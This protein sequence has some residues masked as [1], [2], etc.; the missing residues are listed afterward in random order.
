MNKA[1][2]NTAWILGEKVMLALAG[3]FI[4]V[5]VARYLGP[6]E[7][8]LISLALAIVALITPMVKMGG[9]NVVFNRL[10]RNRHSGLLLMAASTRVRAIN[11]VIICTLLTIGAW[12]YFDTPKQMA[13]FSIIIWGSFFT[14]NEVYSVFFNSS[15]DS[16]F[17]TVAQ[18]IALG[19]GVA[20]KFAFIKLG[21]T[22]GFFAAANIIQWAV[23][24]FIKQHLFRR[25]TREIAHTFK[26]RSRRHSRHIVQVGIPLA[27]SSLSIALYTRTD[28]I[29]LGSM[30]DE[31]HVGWYSAA[32]TLSQGWMMFPM[33]LMT[34]WMV[35]INQAAR[36]SNPALFEHRIRRL[37][38]AVFVVAVI[39]A[40]LMG[41]FRVELI[42]L[43]YGD[44]YGPAASVLGI[45]VI[46]SVF[47][48]LGTSA[49]N[50]IT[51]MG[52]Y[53]F[54]LKKMLFVSA[55]NIVL[56]YLLIPHF[57]L[58]GAALSTL[59]AEILSAV[60]LNLFYRRGR[61]L[62][63]QMTAFMGARPAP[64]QAG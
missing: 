20:L 54:L 21:A 7:F 52:G 38:L 25:K 40:T 19:V 30:L 2:I 28:Q 63:L 53:S 35:G 24:Y 13:V 47:S 12:F 41:I 3:I 55:L 18:N 49:F 31:T 32:L 42:D 46:S 10:A 8:G 44:E 36:G 60:V 62:K 56:N 17:N 1:L 33:A 16:K 22:V 50:V 57:G 51:V 37:F 29:M 26:T 6:S 15:L 48:V 27:I 59:I 9:D 4:T 61:V 58:V 5:Y 14:T 45:T 34:S 64:A 43:L 11:F 23:S 39:P